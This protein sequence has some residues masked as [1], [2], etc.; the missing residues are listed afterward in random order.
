M[1]RRK[2]KIPT[3]PVALAFSL[4]SQTLSP[5]QSSLDSETAEMLQAAMSTLS[6]DHRTVVV[7]RFFNEMSLAEI[8]ESTGWRTGTVK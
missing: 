6:I 5:E 4:E 2:K 8:A 3:A 7:F 1:I